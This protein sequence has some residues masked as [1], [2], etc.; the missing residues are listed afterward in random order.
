MLSSKKWKRTGKCKRDF[1]NGW[2]LCAYEPNFRYPTF[3]TRKITFRKWLHSLIKTTS[4]ILSIPI[5]IIFF[6][7]KLF[8]PKYVLKTDYS[9]SSVWEG[10]SEH[11]F[12]TKPKN[13]DN[14]NLSCKELFW[15]CSVW[16]L[17][18][19]SKSKFKFCLR[20]TKIFETT[21]K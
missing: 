2:R 14:E 9:N 21:A 1:G 10:S 16:K 12:Q 15:A 13:V 5:Q 3:I 6:L 20:L 19:I 4:A 7:R 8:T 17:R 18:K 11:F